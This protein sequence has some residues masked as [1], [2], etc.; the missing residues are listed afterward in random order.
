[1]LSSLELSEELSFELSEE[2]SE[3]SRSR[4]LLFSFLSIA[5]HLVS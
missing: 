4:W 1:M 5:Y 3:L 2:L